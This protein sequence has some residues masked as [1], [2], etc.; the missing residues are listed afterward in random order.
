MFARIYFLNYNIIIIFA[1][2]LKPKN[3]KFGNNYLFLKQNIN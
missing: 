3:L 2:E 1:K